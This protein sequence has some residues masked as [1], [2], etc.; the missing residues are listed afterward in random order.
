[1]RVQVRSDNET[2]PVNLSLG[3]RP[4]F[5]GENLGFL[6]DSRGFRGGGAGQTDWEG[7]LFFFFFF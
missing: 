6:E 2:S 3:L 5:S 1:M 4:T 7:L